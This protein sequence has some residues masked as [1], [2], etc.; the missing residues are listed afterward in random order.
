[1]KPPVPR[2]YVALRAVH[3]VLTA[4][5]MPLGVLRFVQLVEAGGGQRLAIFLVGSLLA[6]FVIAMDQADYPLTSRQA[7]GRTGPLVVNL[8]FG[9]WS[10]EGRVLA[11]AHWSLTSLLTSL[12][13]SLFLAAVLALGSRDP[14]MQKNRGLVL[15]LV[16]PLSLA[17]AGV[18]LIVAQP[19]V[20][21]F[22]PSAPTLLASLAW[23]AQTV[24]T[25]RAWVRQSV[26]SN[27]TKTGE[28]RARAEAMGP[29]NGPA[30]LAMVGVMASLAGVL[31][32]TMP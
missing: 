5:V 25:T 1:M 4:A 30:A 8:A 26:F 13:A 17:A 18:A 29:W 27:A 12:A 21:A 19:L 23:T 22:T 14:Q 20:K 24:S 31:L 6:L 11:A 3:L 16:L 32:F 9:F 10:G 7:L 15:G 28:G 2:A